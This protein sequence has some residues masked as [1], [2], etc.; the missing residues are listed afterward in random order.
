MS[1]GILQFHAAPEHRAFIGPEFGAGPDGI[2]PQALSYPEIMGDEKLSELGREVFALLRD[3]L[4]EHAAE[5][6]RELSEEE[7]EYRRK[8][9]GWAEILEI[10]LEETL[11]EL[12][13]LGAPAGRRRGAGQGE[14]LS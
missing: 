1:E 8:L 6:P 10:M 3:Q 5:A 11:V 14:G 7:D 2:D 13:R 9:E 12:D 4:Q